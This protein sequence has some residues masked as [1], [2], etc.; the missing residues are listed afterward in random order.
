MGPFI[1]PE[2]GKKSQEKYLENVL[3]ELEQTR[4]AM[5]LGLWYLQHEAKVWK[6][7]TAPFSAVDHVRISLQM[8]Y[9][10]RSS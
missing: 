9:T 4:W 10:G 1:H 5:L 3:I 8:Q 6:S 2:E 7:H